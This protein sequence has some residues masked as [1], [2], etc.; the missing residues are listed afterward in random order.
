M[1]RR[2][3]LSR[4][5]PVL[6]TLLVVGSVGC[7]DGGPTQPLNPTPRPT[8]GAAHVAVSVT[9]SPAD[10]DRG[11]KHAARADFVATE[12]AGRP[13]KVTG[14][15]ASDFYGASEILVSGFVAAVELAGGET[16]AFS[17]SLE[18]SDEIPCSDGISF[19][20][21]TA[22]TSPVSLMVGCELTDWPF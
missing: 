6:G 19:S 10:S 1:K 13:A 2:F 14:V 15:R 22:D 12:T 7:G 5:A 18:T 17:V 4:L 8:P 3:T 20:V 9:L 21:Y 16:K 11:F